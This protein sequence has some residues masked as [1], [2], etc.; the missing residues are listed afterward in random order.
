[1]VSESCVENPRWWLCV[2]VIVDAAITLPRGSKS[3]EGEA[4]AVR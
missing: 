3:K 4:L 1:M 2:E